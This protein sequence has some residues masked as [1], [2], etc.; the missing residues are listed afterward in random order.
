MRKLLIALVILLLP[1]CA[2]ADGPDG[3]TAELLNMTDMEFAAV[4]ETALAGTKLS[5]SV[6][7]VREDGEFALARD[8]YDAFA[9]MLECLEVVDK[10][11]CDLRDILVGLIIIFKP[12][13][14][15]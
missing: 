6:V 9:V 2:L 13:I 3:F 11:L 4:C 7:A 5:G 14:R 12:A 10:V 15:H 8:E 1:A